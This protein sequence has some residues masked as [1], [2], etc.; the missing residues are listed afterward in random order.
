MNTH[1]RMALCSR[2]SEFWKK[3]GH[4]NKSLCLSTSGHRADSPLSKNGKRACRC[5]C[6]HTRKSRAQGQRLQSLAFGPEQALLVTVPDVQ[7]VSE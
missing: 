7:E 6:V 3:N 2:S 5:V 1:I 4:R